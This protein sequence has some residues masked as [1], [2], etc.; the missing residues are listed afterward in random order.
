MI[1]L[2]I[3]KVKFLVPVLLM[4]L[5]AGCTV[6]TGSRNVVSEPREVSNFTAVALSGSG[7][8]TI[9]QGEA[10]TLVVEA[11]DNLLELIETEVRNGTLHLGFRSGVNLINPSRAVQYRLTVRD[12]N[13][14]TVSGSGN[15]RVGSLVGE[16]MTIIV[17]GSGD[18]QI[19][20]LTAGA[21]TVTISGSGDVDLVGAAEQQSITVSGSGQYRAADLA[22][23]SANVQ[24]SG[25]GN[26]TLWV[27]E[28][29]D[30]NVSGSGNVEYYGS[31]RI[32]QRV[33]GSGAIRSLGDK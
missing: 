16:E 7:N 17:S 11:D 13:A 20:R 8:L 24:I 12:L 30:V 2:M 5:L 14:L 6:V 27:A 10:E 25:S 9:T 18:V 21:V 4:L 31:P 19:D 32:N 26:T 1:A 15:A 23:N 28:S 3:A 22:S 29:L 33:S